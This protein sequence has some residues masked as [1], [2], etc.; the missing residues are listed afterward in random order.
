[1]KKNLKEIALFLSAEIEQA[2]DAP[3][4]ED[5]IITGVSGLQNAGGESLSFYKDEKFSGHLA[6]TGAAAVLAPEGVDAS[7]APC[8][9]LRTKDVDMALIMAI[10]IFAKNP[11]PEKRELHE[12]A[13]V[14]PEAVLGE[15]VHVGPHAVVEAGAKIGS[16]TVVM[17]GAYVGCSTLIG[18]DCVIWPN[19]VIREDVTVG[20][21]VIIHPC[22][23]I[24]CDGFGFAPYEGEIRKLPQIGTVEIGD[25]VEIGACV[26][27]D[28]ARF[29]KTVISCGS[30]LDNLVH[31]AHNVSIGSRSM[32]AA[33]TGIAGS[34]AVGDDVQFGGQTGVG[35]H[36][37]VGSRVM[38]GGKA[39]ITKNL[40]DGAVVKGNPAWDRRR[41]D[42]AQAHI[43]RLPDMRRKVRDLEERVRKLEKDAEDHKRGGRV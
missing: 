2:E 11:L 26:T 9:V 6:A 43:R 3:D 36:V 23:V 13:V 17:A 10:N 5:V 37:S 38:A 30:K 32:L 24:G 28:R 34:S 20:D 16:N 8:P 40:P 12:T 27:V 1:M 21:R 39:G 4:A 33:Q 7:A 18:A 15:N 22:A 25:D 14:S 35:G 29:D 19:A 42:E 31:I 41:E